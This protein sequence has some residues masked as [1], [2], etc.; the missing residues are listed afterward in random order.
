[1]ADVLDQLNAALANQ[2][3][4]ECVLGSGGMA[5]VY[6]AE[7]L[8]HHRRVAIKVLKPDLAAAVG[9]ERFLREIEIAASLHHPHVLPL[10]D[11][12]EA[13][14]FLYY[15]MPY[16][17]G[18]SLRDRLS[19]ERQL[20]I[21]EALQIAR[22]V[23][24]AL[25]SAH[26]RGIVHRDI[27]PENILLEEGH[28][29]V[30]DFGVARA[31]SGAA[32]E[33]GTERGT[34]VGTPA[35][36][37]PEQAAGEE[38]LDGR[39]DLYSLGC[40]LYEIL[41]GDP[42]FTASTPQAVLARKLADP[43]P[44]L[45]VVRESVPDELEEIVN[46]TLARAP[47]DRFATA[48][49]LVD[50]LSRV[51]AVPAGPR[52]TIMVRG[53]KRRRR[54]LL[55]VIV[56]VA[57]STAIVIRLLLSN[58]V[59][60]RERDWIVIADLDNKTDDV[61][62][63]RSLDN[64]FT[65]ALA[66]SRYVNVFPQ[67]QIA[68]T[69]SRMGREGTEPLDVET[70][71]EVAQRE[72]VKAVVTL[73]I[74][75]LD[76]TYVLTSN[77]LDPA[78]GASVQAQSVRAVGQAS[79]LLALDSLARLL[80]AD[81]GES[82]DD[83]QERAVLLPQA[84]T[85]S[86]EALKKFADGSGAWSEGRFLEARALWHEAVAL[87][88]NFAWAHAML[89]AAYTWTNDVLRGEEEFARA[90]AL[91]D[92]LTD[93]E[94][95]WVRSLIAGWQGNRGEAI[96]L[97][98]TYLQQY[99]DDRNAWFNLGR[100][101]QLQGRSAEALEAYRRVLSLNENDQAAFVNSA[102]MYDDLERYDEAIA[103]FQRAFELNPSDETRVSGD[104]NR[105]YGFVYAKRGDTARARATF[106]KMLSGDAEQRANGLRSLGLLEMY[107]GRYAA[108]IE[109]LREA[110]VGTRATDAKLSEY[111]N[112]LYVA[113]AHRARGMTEAL[114]AEL[115][116]ADRLTGELYIGPEWLVLLGK[117]H[118]R[119]GDL[120]RAVEILQLLE[121]RVNE[122]SD[123]DRATRALLGGEIALARGDHAAA[124][125]S[126]ELARTLHTDNVT[127]ESLAHTHFVSGEFDRARDAYLEILEHKEFGW[128]GQEPWLQAHYWLGRVYEEQGDTARAAESYQELIGLWESGDEGLVA[129]VDA[130]QRLRALRR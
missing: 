50:A 46:R 19:R 113:E 34:T 122:S 102:L 81:L 40:V 47:A 125:E 70:A 20:P 23:A 29:T 75:Q 39:S 36:M 28:A 117:L 1:M 120:E 118:A 35:Y 92:R 107:T 86:L 76:S 85:S 52:T 116:E 119:S 60:F 73:E 123:H 72:N 58:D 109:H 77:L 62:F 90:S 82:L 38:K 83:I 56:A 78:T 54:V 43:V 89:G 97:L 12:G 108:G 114:Q 21:D 17:E 30:S 126:L 124:R 88:S 63:D 99:P 13:D 74:V 87:D 5:T 18:E 111:R 84:T 22:E 112:R 68:Q 45:R 128:E 69:L 48:S 94:R 15:V 11:S 93:R 65:T 104:L 4:A 27:K 100:Q 16:V 25:S 49:Q 57:A 121:E 127:R 79:V 95:L 10:Y 101:L 66:Q 91:L 103:S 98:R 67:A 6:L 37:S 41:G 7:D 33:R 130:R 14:G 96:R 53:G 129:L 31:I 42:P 9:A 106:S 8:K 51:A 105:I 115:R 26:S 24:D 61:V 44:S 110:V 32:G 80:R 3:A 71:R 2:Y 55:G 59:G 64:A